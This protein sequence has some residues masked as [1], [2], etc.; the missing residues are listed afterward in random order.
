MQDEIYEDLFTG[1][2]SLFTPNSGGSIHQESCNEGDC[3]EFEW[4]GWSNCCT[5][6]QN[7]A[8]QVKWKGNACTGEWLEEDQA[9]IEEDMAK[10][11]K[12]NGNFK[13]LNYL[14]NLKFYAISK[15]F[16]IS[17]Y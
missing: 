16:F 1:E 14:A 3:C 15:Y 6:N 2:R 9:C 17:V 8:R 12:M 13:I 4:S 5:N 11:E 7:K 10:I